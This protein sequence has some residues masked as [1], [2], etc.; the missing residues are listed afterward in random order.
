MILKK[1][2]LPTILIEFPKVQFI[3]TAGKAI[4]N[5]IDIAFKTPAVRFLGLV[6]GFIDIAFKTPTI[7]FVNAAGAA[8]KN[9]DALVPTPV[10]SFFSRITGMFDSIKIFDSTLPKV[11]SVPDGVKSFFTKTS[12]FFK[13]IKTFFNRYQKSS[14]FC[15]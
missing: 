1:I 13:S 11:M 14:W 10:L 2:R 7:R 4:T 3:D 9:L 15:K 5:F 12:D 6:D 8:I